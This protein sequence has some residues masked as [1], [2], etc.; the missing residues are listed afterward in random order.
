VVNNDGTGAR[1]L[2]PDE[3][4]SQYPIAWSPDGSKLLYSSEAWGNDLAITDAAGSAPEVLPNDSLCPV[5]AQDCHASLSNVAFSPD[6][7]RL[8][9]A[10]FTDVDPSASPCGD[11]G[12]ELADGTIAVFEIATGRV[13]RLDA[14]EISGPLKCCDGYYAPSWSADGTRLAF[15]KPPL[16][17][18]T[19][20]VDGS[21]LRRLVPVGEG[22]SGTAPLWSPDG[23]TIA[24]MVCGTRPAIYLVQ[25]DGGDL[26]TLE[27]DA[28]DLQW[29]RDGRIVF[30]RSDDPSLSN[31]IM[32]ADGGNVRRLD[33][34][35]A[36]LTAAGCIV[37]RVG[38]V[39]RFARMALW[40][41]VT[42]D[43]P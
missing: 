34:T 5:A 38:D 16:T 14:S 28:C 27:E 6:G 18:F 29:T 20:S 17:S 36:A 15:A 32:D 10:I 19:I 26:R 35:I 11:G 24:S 37:C 42:T 25:P 22:A 31:W 41:P 13:T 1:E 3:P 4:G 40:Q 9:Y 8:A 12:C 21:D 33:D 30:S 7:G 2:R 23:S 43:Q 39:D